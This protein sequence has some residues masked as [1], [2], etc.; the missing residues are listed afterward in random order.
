MRGTGISR[1]DRYRLCTRAG[2]A[3]IRAMTA[4]SCGLGSIG[5]VGL[6]MALAGC[7]VE[8]T[9]VATTFA[10]PTANPSGTPPT[11]QGG[12]EAEAT[13]G[14]AGSAGSA[15]SGATS[16]TP[17]TSSEGSTGA[18]VN[19]QPENGMYSECMNAGDCIGLTTCVIAGGT[20]FCSS[21]CSNPIAD[22]DPNPSATATAPAA[23]VDNGAG[24]Q[25]C[26]LSCASGQTCPGGM[27]CVA[28]GATM[29]CA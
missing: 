26:A 16:M 24:L 19:E 5:R 14:S 21:G 23:C 1:A 18:P 6:V 2:D 8:G 7:T 29:V 4:R 17:A 11:S 12:S 15:E 22:C 9:D 28:L 20:G 27:D 10:D 25:V 3:I 13:D